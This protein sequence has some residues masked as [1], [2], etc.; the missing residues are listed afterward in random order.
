MTNSSL[1]KELAQCCSKESCCVD[2]EVVLV[3]NRLI[4]IVGIVQ[5]WKTWYRHSKHNIGMNGI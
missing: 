5:A 3:L 1:V 4:G 2:T